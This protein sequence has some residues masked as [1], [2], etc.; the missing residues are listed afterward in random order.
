MASSA[1]IAMREGTRRSG[2]RGRVGCEFTWD[3]C[4]ARGQRFAHRPFLGNHPQIDP[5]ARGDVLTDPCQVGCVHH[6]A[7]VIDAENRIGDIGQIQDL[8][9]AATLQGEIGRVVV[10]RRD[11]AG[12][13]RMAKEIADLGALAV[14]VEVD[15][16][17]GPQRGQGVRGRAPVLAPG[18]EEGATGR[19]EKCLEPGTQ[20][21][22]LLAGDR[23]ER[24]PHSSGTVPVISVV[25]PAFATRSGITS[26]SSAGSQ[27]A[28][29][30]TLGPARHPSATLM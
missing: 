2:E 22:E 29:L 28:F 5:L 27:R 9:G 14:G 13:T 6:L 8:G 16:A 3:W 18:N 23:H 7:V 25:G 24:L 15:G 12:D 19:F 20:L 11:D 30:L 1:V 4:N 21:A 26:E 10:G 17:V